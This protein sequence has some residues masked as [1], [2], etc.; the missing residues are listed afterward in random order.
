MYNPDFKRKFI[1][2]STTSVNTAKLYA[3]V[4]NKTEPY[5]MKMHLDICDMSSQVM[6]GLIKSVSTSRTDTNVAFVRVIRK[7]I[8]WCNDNGYSDNQVEIEMISDTNIEAIREKCVRSAADLH[9]RL[10]T[11]FPDGD[12]SQ[13]DNVLS[14][15]FWL[16]FIGILH[17]DIMDVRISDVDLTNGVVTFNDIDYHIPR[18][19][20]LCFDRCTDYMRIKDRQD[21]TYLLCIN[22]NRYDSDQFTRVV[23]SAIA[24]RIRYNGVNIKLKYSSIFVSGIF[25]RMYQ[26]ERAGIPVAFQPIAEA[27]VAARTGGADYFQIG[28]MRRQYE[29]DYLVW[30]EA[31]GYEQ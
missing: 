9:R 22:N 28:R 31:F 10:D 1:S 30:K 17:K 16:A 8:K 20:M 4:F 23:S 18:E 21:T 7:Y 6:L 24:Y 14:C 19:A 12:T 13:K 27:V 5:E 11:I 2:A 26:N 15:Y 3:S 29:R 25:C